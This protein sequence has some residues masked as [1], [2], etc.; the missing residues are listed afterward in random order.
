[1]LRD[2]RLQI[3]ILCLL[4]TPIYKGHVIAL[5]VPPVEN[6]GADKKV[7]CRYGQQ[8]RRIIRELRDIDATV[9]LVSTTDG[10]IAFI[11]TECAATL[12]S[13]RIAYQKRSI[14]SAL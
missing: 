10:D 13:P 2:E 12:H 6:N 4:R 14:F 11:C 3:N 5:S 8:R 1:M 7:T 9:I